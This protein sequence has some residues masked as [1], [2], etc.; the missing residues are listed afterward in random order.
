MNEPHSTSK[1]AATEVDFTITKCTS[2][3]T[4]AMLQLTQTSNICLVFFY[5]HGSLCA[6]LYT[7]ICVHARLECRERQEKLQLIL[8]MYLLSHSGSVAAS[9]LTSM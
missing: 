4:L 7:S 9:P 6:N 8:K 2:L 1:E 5:L 3:D